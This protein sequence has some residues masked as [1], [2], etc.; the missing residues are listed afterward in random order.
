MCWEVCAILILIPTF[1][2]RRKHLPRLGCWR[3]LHGKCS[4]QLASLVKP[5]ALRK[6]LR[7]KQESYRPVV[8]GWATEFTIISNFV[9]GIKN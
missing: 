2:N 9:K 3:E 4:T 1:M 5:S 8:T 7:G 6:T